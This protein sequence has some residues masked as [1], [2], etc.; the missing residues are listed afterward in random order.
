MLKA[1]KL[2]VKSI[3]KAINDVDTLLLPRH[4]LV[5]LLKFIPTE[6]ELLALKGIDSSDVNNLAFAVSYLKG[7]HKEKFMS[8]IS[9]IDK[10]GDKLQAL[11]FKTSYQEFEDDA[12]AMIASLQDASESV[13]TSKKF[14]ELLKVIFIF[15]KNRLF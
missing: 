9:E 11:L 1:I 13:L 7:S 4:I 12:D 2:D 5:E 14:K 10:Y 6:E 8:E 15:T 3:K